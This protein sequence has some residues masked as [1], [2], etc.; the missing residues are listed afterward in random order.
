MMRCNSWD[1]EISKSSNLNPNKT[2]QEKIEEVAV[3]RIQMFLLNQIEIN[4]VLA[5]ITII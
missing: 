1:S 3:G 2:L 5:S 4:T